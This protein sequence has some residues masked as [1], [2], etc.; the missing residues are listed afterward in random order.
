MRR[1][2]LRGCNRPLDERKFDVALQSLET[3]RSID[4][5]D[6]RLAALDERIATLRAEFGPAQILAAINAQNFDRAAQLIDE[7]AR[8]KSLSNAKLGPAARGT[9]PP[10][11]EESDVANL[12]KLI[13]TRLQQDK[14]LEPRND[15]AVYYLAPGP[16]R[17]APAPPRCSRS[18]RKS[19]SV[20]RRWCTP[21]STSGISP[22]RT[23]C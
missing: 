15:S 17:R 13:D 3:A 6:S 14:V 22:T 18:P 5:G 10:A 19:T 7:A 11:P 21:P 8:S 9:A 2:C 1:S 16:Q 23:G 4:P 20:W 12:V